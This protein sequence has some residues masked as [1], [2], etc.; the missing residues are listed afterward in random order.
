MNKKLA[1]Q[2]NLLAD[3]RV[4]KINKSNTELLLNQAA[5]FNPCIT[6]Y[7]SKTDYLYKQ[8]QIPHKT[9]CVDK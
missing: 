6:L 3:N 4:W 7:H 1:K 9:Y 2:I 5:T 8:L